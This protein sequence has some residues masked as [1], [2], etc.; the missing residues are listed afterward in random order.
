MYI[1]Y[2]T[3]NLISGKKYRGAHKNKYDDPQKFDGYLGSGKAFKIAVQK[4]GR[5]NFIRK[6]H[7]AFETADEMYEAEKWFVDKKITKDT[8]YYNIQEGGRRGP[9]YKGKEHHFYGK[10]HTEETKQKISKAN[11][12]KKRTPELRKHMSETRRG[13][14]NNMYGKKHTPESLAL[15]S[16]NR[17]GK[18]VGKDNPFY[19]QEHTEE[20]KQKIA[21]ANGKP[22]YLNDIYYPSVSEAGRQNDIHEDTIRRRLNKGYTT[23][24]NNKGQVFTIRYTSKNESTCKKSTS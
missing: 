14:N 21:I 1:L 6:T 20:S 5:E 10:N 8:N 17:K 13:K 15:M 16:K 7:F 9:N 18:C 4:H 23:A 2:E 12:N 22:L 19:G 11:K 3:T 24:R